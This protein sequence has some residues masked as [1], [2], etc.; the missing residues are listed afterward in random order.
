MIAQYLSGTGVVAISTLTQW[1]K[2]EE[3]NFV[4]DPLQGVSAVLTVLT[5]AYIV[6]NFLFRRRRDWGLSFTEEYWRIVGPDAKEIPGLEVFVDKQPVDKLTVSQVAFWNS[7]KE[8]ITK[9]MVPNKGALRFR[10]IDGGKLLAA[11]VVADNNHACSFTCSIEGNDCIVGFDF[12]GPNHGA[13]LQVL[14]TAAAPYRE[15]RFEAGFLKP[16]KV[17]DTDTISSDILTWIEMGGALVAALSFAVLAI[18]GIV[19]V[20]VRDWSIPYTKSYVGAV[21][22]GGM[23]IFVLTLLLESFWRRRFAMPVS[24]RRLDP[25]GHFV[26]K[27]GS[28][29][30]GFDNVVRFAATPFRIV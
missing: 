30:S 8:N 5:T 1:F 17:I 3:L 20:F 13:F 11:S 28:T 26:L 9:D 24:L 29:K 7:G 16:V 10:I 2:T 22:V 15:T 25:D 23:M 21:F 6:F 12:I 4:H 19:D 14:H 18:N 27:A